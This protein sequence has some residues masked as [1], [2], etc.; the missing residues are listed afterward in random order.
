ML[1]K[2]N[3]RKE[4]LEEK[5]FGSGCNIKDEFHT[6]SELYYHRMIMFSIILK[7]G[8]EKGA[9]SWRSKLHKDGTMFPGFF[10]VGISTPDGDFAYHYQEKFWHHFDCAETL[11][12]APEWDGHGPIDIDRLYT[13]LNKE[14]EC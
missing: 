14:G 6:M 2:E 5:E 7:L 3:F 8:K 4:Y 10:I 11:E 12:F 13:L 9:K 1:T